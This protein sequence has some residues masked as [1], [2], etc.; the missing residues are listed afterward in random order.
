MGAITW[1]SWPCDEALGLFNECN[2][3]E[4]ALHQQI[5]KAVDESYLMALQNRQTNTIDVTI[6]VILDYLFSNHSRLTPAMLQHEEKQIKEMYYDLQ[7]PVDVVFNKVEDPLDL[8]IAARADFTEQQLI[9]IAYVLLT[10]TGKYQHYIREWSRL[11]R[12]QKTWSHFKTYFCRAH[13]ELKESGDLQVKGIPFHSANLVQDVVDGVQ[14][15]LQ[16]SDNTLEDPNTV[17]DQMANN[18][19]QQQ[20]LPKMMA[21]MV[22]MMEQMNTLQQKL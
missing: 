2:N 6:P 22:Q 10:A 17:I 19:A 3:I 15:A 14:T 12:E 20:I 5:I 16:S 21:Q 9:N 11:D 7:Q 1:P 18:A 8:S 4:Q 13:Q